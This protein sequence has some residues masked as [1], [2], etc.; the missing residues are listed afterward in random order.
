MKAS[1]F[2]FAFSFLL[3]F[4]YKEIKKVPTFNKP[5]I[6]HRIANKVTFG[7]AY[8]A[9]LHAYKAELNAY[10]ESKKQLHKIWD[11]I[12][13]NNNNNLEE[14]KGSANVNNKP[15]DDV[16]RPIDK[17]GKNTQQEVNSTEQASR[18]I[19]NVKKSQD[20]FSI[21]MK[22]PKTFVNKKFKNINTGRRNSLI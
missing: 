15:Q 11:P 12:S 9:E 20:D 8:K 2:T 1:I 4:K 17:E 6:L 13:D 21:G 3:Y 19:Q 5:P 7:H 14:S 10:K 22:Q 18:I 16:L